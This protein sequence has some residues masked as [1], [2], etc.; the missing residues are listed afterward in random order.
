MFSAG[1]MLLLIFA[2]CIILLVHALKGKH[3]A[4]Q[5]KTALK[6]AAPRLPF[7]EILPLKLNFAQN[8]SS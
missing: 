4:V 3:T 1:T 8:M 2:I 6:R 5:N 7:T